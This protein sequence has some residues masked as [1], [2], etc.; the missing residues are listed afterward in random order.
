MIPSG[1][2]YLTGSTSPVI[3]SSL[4]FSAPQSF[5]F[6]PEIHHVEHKHKANIKLYFNARQHF[7]HERKQGGKKCKIEYRIFLLLSIS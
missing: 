3:F 2:E 7:F 5:V 1:S 6:P 4:H